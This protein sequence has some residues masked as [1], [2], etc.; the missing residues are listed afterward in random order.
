MLVTN[1]IKC[2]NKTKKEEYLEN[3]NAFE[4]SNSE[5]ISDFFN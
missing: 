4:F 3:L 2:W 1:V 5:F